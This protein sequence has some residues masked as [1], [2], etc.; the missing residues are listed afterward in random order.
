MSAPGDPPAAA[1]PLRLVISRDGVWLHDDVEVTHPG[2]VASLWSNLQVDAGGHYVAVGSHRVP[3]EVEDAPF[4]VVR[5]EREAGGL[6]AW[7]SDGSRETLDPETLVTA[8]DV[9]YARAKGGRFAA[10]FSRAAAWQLWQ[11]AEHD[12]AAARAT[13]V[14]AGRRYPIRA[15]SAPPA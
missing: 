8:G 11:L 6:A 10:R 12:E 5:V 7:L 14:V 4:V 2:I 1:A 13:V 9:P 3:V 15:A